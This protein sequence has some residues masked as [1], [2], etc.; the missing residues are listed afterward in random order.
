MAKKQKIPSG[1]YTTE[2]DI[3][4]KAARNLPSNILHGDEYEVAFSDL[5]VSALFMMAKT[6]VVTR[7][8]VKTGV[9]TA[10]EFTGSCM[11]KKISFK[12][13]QMVIPAQISGIHI[14]GI[15]FGGSEGPKKENKKEKKEKKHQSLSFFTPTDAGDAANKAYVDGKLSGASVLNPQELNPFNE[16]AGCSCKSEIVRDKSGE[17]PVSAECDCESNVCD[18]CDDEGCEDCDRC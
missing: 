15:P 16:C 7:S 5:P 11:S 6:T 13:R 4:K 17:P 2:V 1:V 9:S 18:N 14:T 10:M 3:T 8:F 12:K